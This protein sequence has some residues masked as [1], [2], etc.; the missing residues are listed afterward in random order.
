MI[1]RIILVLGINMLLLRLHTPASIHHLRINLYIYCHSINNAPPSIKST[2]F[3]EFDS[4][5]PELTFNSQSLFFVSSLD[6]SHT[7]PFPLM[8]DV[9]TKHLQAKPLILDWILVVLVSISED[10]GRWSSCVVHCTPPWAQ[11][12]ARKRVEWHCI[13]WVSGGQKRRFPVIMLH[14]YWWWLGTL[15]KSGLLSRRPSW[16]S[17]T[18]CELQVWER[19]QLLSNSK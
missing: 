13:C 10:R 18:Y 9:W 15:D 5:L 3:K 12:M 19:Y 11:Q 6:Q 16:W 17:G 1:S 2:I 14:A 8:R 7:T 4:W